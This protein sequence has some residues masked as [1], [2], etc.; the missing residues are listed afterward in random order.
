MMRF[1][2]DQLLGAGS[3]DTVVFW[4]TADTVLTIGNFEIEEKGHYTIST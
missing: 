1:I 3:D 2:D 4:D